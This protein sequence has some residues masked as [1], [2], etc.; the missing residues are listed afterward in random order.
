MF[1]IKN[2]QT[3]ATT[4]LWKEGG[5][6]AG[7]RWNYGAFGFYVDYEYSILLEGISG[8]TQTIVAVDDIIIKE[9]QY[10]TV[11]PLSAVTGPGLPIPSIIPTTTKA[12]TS[13]PK[14]SIYDCTFEVDFCNWKNDL[15]RPL[16]WTRTQGETE[17]FDTGAQVDH[18]LVFLSLF[19]IL[20]YN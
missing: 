6:D 7:R 11:T 1:Q 9:S 12:P 17:S 16:N 14:P 4:L 15:T 10:C 20:T 18:T 5:N 2:L 3:N 8:G 19:K 13:T